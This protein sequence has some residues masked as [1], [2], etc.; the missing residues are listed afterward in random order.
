MHFLVPTIFSLVVSIGTACFNPSMSS[1][2]HCM[3]FLIPHMLPD[4][5][6]RT[7]VNAFKSTINLKRIRPE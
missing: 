3:D 2:V 4:S 7:D 1:S 5:V 6:H